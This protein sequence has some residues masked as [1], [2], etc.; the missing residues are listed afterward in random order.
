MMTESKTVAK[1]IISG[2]VDP[3]SRFIIELAVP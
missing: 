1:P 2:I 3:S